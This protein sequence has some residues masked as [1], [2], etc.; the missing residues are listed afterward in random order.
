[1]RLD[2][3]DSYLKRFDAVVTDRRGSPDEVWVTLDQS[4]FYP[5]SGGQPHDTGH[6][7]GAE[8]VDVVLEEGRVWHRLVGPAPEPGTLTVGTIDWDR[9]YRHMQRHSAQHLLSQ[10]FVRVDPGF[11]TRS[12]S[13]RGPTCTLDLDGDPT[14][15]H[16][17]RAQTIVNEFGYG[18]LPIEAFEIDESELHAYPLRRRPKVHGRIRLVRMGSVEVSACGGTHLSHTAEALPIVVLGSERIR[19]GLVRVAFRAGWEAI[20]AFGA[21]HAVLHALT[22]ELSAPAAGLIDAVQNL[23]ADNL[24]A[25]AEAEKGRLARAD[26]IARDLVAN[27]PETRRTPPPGTDAGLGATRVSGSDQA[28]IIVR[29]VVEGALLDDVAEALRRVPGIVALLASKEV[30]LA[31]LAF[32]RAD[33]VDLDLRPV[34]RKALAELHGRGGGRPERAQGAGPASARLGEALDAAEAAVRAALAGSDKGEPR[35]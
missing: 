6:L 24:A 22:T 34:L 13:L 10:A 30:P 33:D 1:M 20:E 2:R 12:V 32:A 31:R 18:N 8:V 29:A 21:E 9:R 4:A 27:A 28:P 14:P 17:R 26:A 15:A 7:G 35:G 11:G 25:R 23:R 16:L 19:G 5:S 3:R